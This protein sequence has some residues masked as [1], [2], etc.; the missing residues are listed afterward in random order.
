MIRIRRPGSAEDPDASRPERA[1]RVAKA[2]ERDVRKRRGKLAGGVA[3]SVIYAL[4][5]VAEPWPLK[6]V[7]DQVLFHKPARGIGLKPFTVFG[8]AP[9]AILAAAAIALALAGVVRG[10]SYYYED[11]LLSSA[12]QEIVYAIRS[13]LYRHLHVLPLSFHQQRRT[14]DLLVRLSADI[15]VLRDVLIDFIVNVFSGIV[16]VALMLAIMLLIDPVLTLVSLA[17]MPTVAGLSWVYARR[18]RSNATKQRKREGQVATV[19]HEALSAMSVVQLHGAGDR[20]HQRFHEINRRSLKQ[21]VKGARLEAQ[22]NRGIELALSGGLV[23]ILWVGTLRALHGGLTPGELVVFMAYLRGAYRPLRRTSKSVQ[24]SAKALA[25]AERIV[26]ILE[27]EPELRD[28]PDA[29]PAPALRGEVTFDRLSFGYQP[30][31]EVLH[32]ISFTAPAGARVAIVGRTGSGKSTLLSLVPRLFDPTFGRVLIDGHDVREFTLESLRAQISLVQQEPI[33]FGLSIGENIRYGAPDATD[34]EVYAAAHAAGMDEFVELL[35]D[36]YD[37]VLA[38][39]GSSLSGGQRQRVTIARALV[40]SSPI[41]VLDEPTSGLDAGTEQAILEALRNLMRET[42]TLLVT[43]NMDLV[44]EADEIIVLDQGRIADRGTYPELIERSVMFRGLARRRGQ[45][46]LP[47]PDPDPPRS[48]PSRAPG[49]KQDGPRALFYA[50]NGVGVGHLQRQLDL[51]SAFK[52]RHRDAAVLVATGSHAAGLF[53]IPPGV[54]YVKLPSISMVDR[55]ENWDPRNLPIP[56]EDVVALRSELLEQTVRRFGPDLLVADFM[57]AGPYGEL[58]GALDALHARGG[59]AVAGFRDVIDEPSFVRDLWQRT[60]VYDVL[61]AHYQQICVY[62]TPAM[63]DFAGAYGFDDELKARMH[64][65]G[66][67]GRRPPTAIDTPL[68]ERPLVVANGG[69][70]RDGLELLRA[71]VGAAER[72]R[73]ELGGTW[74]MV[75]G[76]LM[77][78]ATHEQLLRAGESAGLT[79]RRIVPELRAHIALADCVV[80]MAGYNTCCDLLTFR[81]PSVLVPRGGPSQEQ[82]IRTNRLR[83][84]NFV[85]S[86]D[87]RDATPGRL[88]DEIAAALA[89]GPPSPAPVPLDGLDRAVDRFDVALAAA[90]AA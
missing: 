67:L 5:R 24:R 44:R 1:R 20:E 3:F 83:E 26:E 4:A 74:L 8:T 80:S 82:A 46:R 7:F 37:T 61:R 21:G 47:G 14:G 2:F 53:A 55:Y 73:A 27:T 42:T 71:F 90:I 89:A 15:I 45:Q 77:D 70:G 59:V 30:G 58:L 50:H 19:M 76:P 33:L 60:G 29:Q 25:A 81:R 36:G 49:S 48:A 75:T 64:Y 85:R 51:A 86:V 31:R 38:E 88:A 79:V 54:D 69:G 34:E 22:M 32:E 16:L 6:V 35:P 41:L 13:R 68:Y 40:R 62:G 52:G 56:R 57:P 43:H 78:D 9:T 28:A 66:Y 65:T 11:Y 17:V 87:A 84:W 63:I 23:V 10:V 12:S 18:I 39:R 72:M